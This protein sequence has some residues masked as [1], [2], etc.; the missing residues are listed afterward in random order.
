LNRLYYSI[1]VIASLVLIQACRTAPPIEHQSGIQH[2]VYNTVPPL[3]NVPTLRIQQKP[4]KTVKEPE[5]PVPTQQKPAQ[6]KLTIEEKRIKHALALI[7]TMSKEEKI[8][9]LFFLAY[10]KMR[11]GIPVTTYNTTVQKYI[12]RYKPGGM[13]L[14]SVNFKTPDQTRTLISDMQRGTGIPLFIATDEEGGKVS[15]LSSNSAMKVIHMPPASHFSGSLSPDRVQRVE[16]LLAA[17]LKDLGINVDMAPVADVS[18]GIPPD[19]IGS[20]SFSHNPGLAGEY[21]A[22]VVRGLHPR[23]ASVLKHFPGHGNVNGD[24]HS[25]WAESRSSRKDFETIDFVPFIQ[26]IAAGSDFVMTAHISAPALTGNN[27][28]CSLSP[29]VQTDILRNKLRFTGIIITDSMEMGAIKSFYNPGEAALKAFM[30]GADMILMPADTTA[31]QQT[32]LKALRKGV[33]TEKRLNES[34]VRIISLKIKMGMFKKGYTGINRLSPEQKQTNHREMN[35]LL[36][37]VAP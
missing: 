8:G 4:E 29:G 35:N 33:V 18:R 31:A 23:I 20:R 11:N 27:V 30:A 16:E 22:A 21:V 26:G 25:G 7:D 10:R 17:D 19:V 28:P 36:R 9:Q 13:I 12:R 34:L 14:F 3:V 1:L 15:R 2:P 37:N 32:M 24:T 5:A 6:K